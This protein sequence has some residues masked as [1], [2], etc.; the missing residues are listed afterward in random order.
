M[1]AHHARVWSELIAEE[2]SRDESSAEAVL[3]A[4]EEAAAALWESL[5]GIHRPQCD[6]AAA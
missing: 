4:V 2:L 5:D 6:S 1:D 3:A